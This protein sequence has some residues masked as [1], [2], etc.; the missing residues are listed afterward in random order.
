M[1]HAALMASANKRVTM[2]DDESDSNA[3]AGLPM[4]RAQQPF[5]FATDIASF[6]GLKLKLSGISGCLQRTNRLFLLR[7]PANFSFIGAVFFAE[8]TRA[9]RRSPPARC[10]VGRV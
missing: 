1:I 7:L 2:L 8:K 3:I 4:A 9:E 6:I 5:R 10:G